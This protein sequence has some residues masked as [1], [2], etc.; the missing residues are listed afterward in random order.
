MIED[1]LDDRFLTEAYLEEINPAYVINVKYMDGSDDVKGWLLKN[2]GNQAYPD[3]ILMDLKLPGKSGFELLRDIR[4]NEILKS[5]PIVIISGT[6]FSVEVD[7]CY[8][9]GAN[10]FIQKPA[11]LALTEKKIRAFLEYWFEVVTR[12][13]RFTQKLN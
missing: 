9:L 8:R 6:A 11:T 5:V 10:S 1:D 13:E 3:L 2:V 12:P 7:E 4:S